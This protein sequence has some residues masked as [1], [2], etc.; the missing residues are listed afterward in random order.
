MLLHHI[1]PKDIEWLEQKFAK[2]TENGWIIPDWVI[3]LKITEPQG[4]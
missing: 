4:K 1:K 3:L 2:L